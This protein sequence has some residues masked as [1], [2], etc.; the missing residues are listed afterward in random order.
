MARGLVTVTPPASEPVLVSE[1]KQAARI[2]VPDDDLFV[3]GLI[4]AARQ[5]VENRTNLALVTQT[6]QMTLD[7]FPRYSSSA[8]WQYNSDAIWQQRL[9][10]TQLSGQWYP[11]RAAIRVTRP[12]FQAL[13]AITYVDGAGLT[14]SLYNVIPAGVPA[15]GS[16]AVTP[17]TMT[18]VVV[19][20]QFVVDQGPAQEA[21]AVTAVTAT[22]FT[23]TF[24]NA[25]PVNTVVYMNPA[26]TAAVNP[27]GGGPLVS[28]DTTTPVGRIAPGYG[29]IWPIVRQQLEAVQVTYVAGFGGLYTVP[30]AIKTAIKMLVA[31]WY[32][33]REAV[34]PGP[35]SP[36]P[37]AVE[38]LLMAYWPGE[39][40]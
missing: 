23:A 34:T 7:R 4:T 32:E 22:T 10:V 12:P 25:H 26:G 40:E 28:V 11:D 15:P 6:L 37:M 17:Y 20:A 36:V 27:F 2:D 19:G 9:P 35:L 13:Q 31:H 16:Q 33:N 3:L 18:G 8:I 29:Q 5:Y 24:L 39:Y 14:Q 1:A 21:V 38:A 30:D